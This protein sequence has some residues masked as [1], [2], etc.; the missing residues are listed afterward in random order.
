M[1]TTRGW[2]WRVAP[3][4]LVI[5]CYA[6]LHPFIHWH[7]GGGC[8]MPELCAEHSYRVARRVVQKKERE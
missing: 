2:L 3:D 8:R 7:G 5:G 1:A 4:W 6:V